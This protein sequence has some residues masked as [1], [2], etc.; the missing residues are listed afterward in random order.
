MLSLQIIKNNQGLVRKKWTQFG[1]FN[2]L[3][4]LLV[5]G[6]SNLVLGSEEWLV[7]RIKSQTME[8]AH[9]WM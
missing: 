4:L 3:K 6:T 9:G 5:T 7:V 8:V 1:G 2:G